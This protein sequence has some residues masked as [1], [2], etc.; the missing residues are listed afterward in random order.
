[1]F[2]QSDSQLKAVKICIGHSPFWGIFKTFCC[3]LLSLLLIFQLLGSSFLGY[4][5][6]ASYPQNSNYQTITIQESQFNFSRPNDSY[7]QSNKELSLQKILI[8]LFEIEEENETKKLRKF[9]YLVI[10]TWLL[11]H[12]FWSSSIVPFSYFNWETPLAHLPRYLRFC[13]LKIP[14]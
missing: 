5:N 13:N 9:V 12:L 7:S 8:S 3:K 4:R 14:S 11:I 1:M 10:T 2:F 6:Y